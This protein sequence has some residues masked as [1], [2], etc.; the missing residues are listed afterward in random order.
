MAVRLSD[1]EVRLMEI[2]PD[3]NVVELLLTAAYAAA[4]AN[5]KALLPS[6]PITNTNRFFAALGKIPSINYFRASRN[7]YDDIHAL[8]I[9]AE[10]LL[11]WASSQ[12]R[13]FLLSVPQGPF[14]VA[15]L[16][17]N[18]EQFLLADAG[19]SLERA[20]EAR[21]RSYTPQ[22][23]C[24][25]VYFHGTTLDR[26]YAIL[27]QGLRVLSQDSSLRSNGASYGSGIYL[28]D[29]IAVALSY[30][31]NPRVSVTTRTRNMLFYSYKVLLCVELG[32]DVSPA[33]SWSSGKIF[34]LPDEKA[35]ILRYV[36]LIPREAG[37][38]TGEAVI[39]RTIGWK[40]QELAKGKAGGIE[41]AGSGG[42]TSS[43]G[44][45][46]Y[47]GATN[48]GGATSYRTVASYGGVASSGGIASSKNALGDWLSFLLR[49]AAY[50]LGGLLL[51]CA[52]FYLARQV[53]F[54]SRFRIGRLAVW[55]Q[56]PLKPPV[57]TVR[58]SFGSHM[59]RALWRQ[60]PPPAVPTVSSYFGSHVWRAIWRKTPAPQVP[61]VRVWRWYSDK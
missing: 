51:Y 59:W 42:V 33:T 52:L 57:P 5:N 26:L 32:T 4:Q 18:T 22:Q 58:S 40:F 19:P 39:R 46:G 15:G 47:S 1:L 25:V 16:P 3:P 38:V 24:D 43:A 48:Y 61:T 28:T 11:C 9:E 10:R 41:G 53:F 21:R 49:L 12:Y 8:G 23:P 14:H 29:S 56:A 27:T 37:A 6:C 2:R 20:F 31:G 50:C 55:R 30:A 54:L 34:V 17:P 7:I 44:A 35:V 60:S 13:G 45:A 36:F